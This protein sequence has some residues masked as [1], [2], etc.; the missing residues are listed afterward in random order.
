MAT[1]RRA[2]AY[3]DGL[4]DLMTF[5]SCPFITGETRLNM[6][7]ELQE[8]LYGPQPDLSE[9]MPKTPDRA[10]VFRAHALGVR[11]DGAWAQHIARGKHARA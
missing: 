1:K 3:N 4:P 7:R 6:C 8:I 9:P 5:L 11:L 2:G 10:D